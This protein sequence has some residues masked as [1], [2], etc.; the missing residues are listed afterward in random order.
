[1]SMSREKTPLRIRIPLTSTDA[2]RFKTLRLSFRPKTPGAS[3]KVPVFR[4]ELFWNGSFVCMNE[5][6]RLRARLVTKF[7]PSRVRRRGRHGRADAERE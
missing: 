2:Y 6:R 5:H 1:M 7:V 3:Q 4:T